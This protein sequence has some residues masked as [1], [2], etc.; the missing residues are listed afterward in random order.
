M[1]WIELYVEPTPLHDCTRVASI[2]KKYACTHIL[3]MALWPP[4]RGNPFWDIISSSYCDN[5][6]WFWMILVSPKFHRFYHF[7]G[8]LQFPR[9]IPLKYHLLGWFCPS[10]TTKNIFQILRL[11]KF[12]PAKWNN[13]KVPSRISVRPALYLFSLFPDILEVSWNRGTTKSS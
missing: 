7:A 5:M 13:I 4:S 1:V 3:S 9:Q 6:W 2:R 10:L 12:S 8:A 11:V